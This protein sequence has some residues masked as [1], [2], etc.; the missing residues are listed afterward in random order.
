MNDGGLCYRSLSLSLNFSTRGELVWD[1][2]LGV[3]NKS[4]PNV[5]PTLNTIFPVGIVCGFALIADS[6]DGEV[7]QRE[8][9]LHC[10]PPLPGG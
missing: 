6:I 1:S 2:I 10:S 7:R 5:P 9:D 8:Q 3:K 4:Q